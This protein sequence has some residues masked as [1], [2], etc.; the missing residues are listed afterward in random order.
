[1]Y[2]GLG[3]CQ[4]LRDFIPKENWLFPIGPINSQQ[5]L[6]YGSGLV[7]LIHVG[8][9]TSLILC[10][11]CTDNHSCYELVSKVALAYLEDTVFA[12]TLPK[13]WIL[14]PSSHLLLSVL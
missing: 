9:Q 11:S 10:K 14:Q 5:L 13:L 8:E 3:H 6:K 7:S 12:P 4:P 1:M 2:V